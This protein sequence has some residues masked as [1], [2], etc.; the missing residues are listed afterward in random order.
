[1]P[2]EDLHKNKCFVAM[3]Y[4]REYTPVFE[5]VKMGALKAGFEVVFMDQ[6]TVIPGK[7]FDDTLIEGIGQA[8]IMIADI[9]EKN[10]N[11]LFEVGIAKGM[12]K[13]LL[14]L[15][16]SDK[17]NLPLDL[18]SHWVQVYTHTPDGLNLLSEKIKQS[19]VEYMISPQK[20]ILNRKFPASPSFFVDWDKLNEREVENLCREL[21]SQLGFHEI[22]WE[23]KIPGFDLTAEFPRKDP[24]GF[25]YK[26]LW[27]IAFSHTI[28][29]D[30]LPDNKVKNSL[31]LSNIIKY[32]QK[33]ST[34]P[35]FNRIEFPVT[36]L[37]VMYQGN[38]ES[39]DKNQLHQPQEDNYSM[40]TQVS[41]HIRFRVWDQEYLTALINRFPHVGY[42][43]FSDEARIRSRTRKTYEELYRENSDLISRQARLIS[44]LKEEKNLRIRAE[45]DSVWKNISFSAA[46]K[47]GNPLFAIETDLEP[48]RKRI[49]EQRN[50]EAEEVI[51][52]IRSSVEKAKGFVEQFKSLARAQEI[53]P[54]RIPLRPILEDACSPLRNQDIIYRVECPTD[55]YVLADPD[56][57]AECFDELVAN[58]VQWMDKPGKIEIKAIFPIPQPLPDI[59]DLSHQY[60]LVQVKDNGPGIPIPDKKKIFEA[61]ITSS[62]QGTG[63]GLAL[64]RRIIDGHGGTVIESG[65][66]GQGATF[67]IYLPLPLIKNNPIH[68]SLITT[69]KR[70]NKRS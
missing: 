56:R 66:P 20:F 16:E 44:E 33:K 5:S 11:V 18:R 25:E 12:G 43:Y 1:M 48:L 40:D 28:K 47:I 60:T 6:I 58:A 64:V 2:K 9:S 7:S 42:K 68:K 31:L 62:N 55:L 49:R 59:L 61:F 13:Q 27:L 4:N 37:L 53:R 39:L 23:H 67:E 51:E 63:L 8:D 52:N 21:L 3:P 29:T 57:L 10:L 50:Q 15:S 19:L 41:S 70:K 46:H 69:G 54:V 17:I 22:D 36:V 30:I 45:R 38:K 26:E 14:L 35:P 34:P 32:T 24:D 65:I